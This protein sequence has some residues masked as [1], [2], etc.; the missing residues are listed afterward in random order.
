MEAA[1]VRGNRGGRESVLLSSGLAIS[2]EE[3]RERKEEGI[4]ARGTWI[5][6]RM[7]PT[8]DDTHLTASRAL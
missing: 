8:A 6:R 7:Q 5:E 3:T 1:D 4:K 2:R